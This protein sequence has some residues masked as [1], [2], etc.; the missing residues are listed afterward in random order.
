MIWL[1]LL[2]WHLCVMVHK[3]P[4]DIRTYIINCLRDICILHY[5][6]C[7]LNYL[8]LIMNCWRPFWSI[9]LTIVSIFFALEHDIG[10]YV[11]KPFD[12][13]IWV[14]KPFWLEFGFVVPLPWYYWVFENFVGFLLIFGGFDLSEMIVKYHLQRMN[15]YQIFSLG[16]HCL[17]KEDICFYHKSTRW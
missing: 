11:S 14:N 16:I 10:L 9:W 8:S 7:W 3:W 17:S 13:E 5:Y 1:P 2:V 12:F 15:Q 6:N 4:S